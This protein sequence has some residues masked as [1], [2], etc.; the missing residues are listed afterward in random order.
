MS[1]WAELKCCR[2][3]VNQEQVSHRQLRTPEYCTAACGNKQQLSTLSNQ[4]H[5]I[6]HHTTTTQQS[7][8]Q[9][10]ESTMSTPGGGGISAEQ[11]KARYVG[12][13]KRCVAILVI[14]CCVLLLLG[15]RE[16]CVMSN[17]CFLSRNF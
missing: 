17:R 3:R 6:T 13:G 16:T 9:K 7:L 15:Y 4:Q 10:K 11:L 5:S 12:T 8:Y 2:D 14:Q 1:H